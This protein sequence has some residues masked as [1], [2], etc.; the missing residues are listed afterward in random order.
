M[1]RER[2]VRELRIL[3]RARRVQGRMLKGLAGLGML[4]LSLAGLA[5]L[6]H[7]NHSWFAAP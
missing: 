2:E 4:L 6:L 7:I 3:L 1:S 5:L